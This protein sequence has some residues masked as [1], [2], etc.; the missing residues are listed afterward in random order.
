MH[1]ESVLRSAHDA[2]ADACDKW[3]K[4]DSPE[5]F[6]FAM[7]SLMVQR[8]RIAAILGISQPKSD[9]PT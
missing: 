9:A 3:A 2:I 1:A 7:K 8:D 6:C 4:T 5:A